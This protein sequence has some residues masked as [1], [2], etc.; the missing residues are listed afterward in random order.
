MGRFL[1]GFL[2]FAFLME[3]PDAE[4]ATE[5]GLGRGPGKGAAGGRG[6]GQW[7]RRP[8]RAEHTHVGLLRP[9]CI[10]GRVSLAASVGPIRAAPCG[11]LNRLVPRSEEQDEQSS[12]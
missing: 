9:A 12:S 6:S 3:Q 4:G 1:P 7:Q 10:Q 5:G 11:F 8:L 2:T